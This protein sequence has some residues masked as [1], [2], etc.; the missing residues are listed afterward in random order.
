MAS[1]EELMSVLNNNEIFRRADGKEYGYTEIRMTHG[2]CIL[3]FLYTYVPSTNINKLS[4]FMLN[5]VTIESEVL[6]K[7]IVYLNENAR[8][9]ISD[10]VNVLATHIIEKYKSVVPKL[11][12]ISAKVDK[13]EK[14]RREQLKLINKANSK[15]NGL[16]MDVRTGEVKFVMSNKYLL[17]TNVSVHN[18]KV[19]YKDPIIHGTFSVEQIRRLVDFLATCPE[20]T[21]DR[22]V[23]K[24]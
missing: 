2:R 3:K 18:N 11:E 5:V 15:I 4:V 13:Q 8:Y 22:L 21:E 7:S 10:D 23:N 6:P 19:V 20:A 14:E 17:R 24:I 12:Q 9:A 1:I 16:E